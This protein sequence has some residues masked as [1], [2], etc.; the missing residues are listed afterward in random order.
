MIKSYTNK[1][2]L[3]DRGSMAAHLAMFGGYFDL[4]R[5]SL[6]EFVP[7]ASVRPAKQM[8]TYSPSY[9]FSRTR[10]GT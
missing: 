4:G 3:K 5:T 1:A 7:H 9:L 10:M 8:S 6:A 2:H